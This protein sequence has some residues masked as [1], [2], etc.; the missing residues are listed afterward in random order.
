MMPPSSRPLAHNPTPDVQDAEPNH[1]TPISYVTESP[2]RN[3]QKTMEF[4]HSLAFELLARVLAI[5]AWPRKFCESSLAVAM[6]AWM[7][8]KPS[9]WFLNC[10]CA[11]SPL[12]VSPWRVSLRLLILLKLSSI[13][14]FVF[15]VDTTI[16]ELDNILPSHAETL[17]QCVR[18]FNSVP[19]SFVQ[20]RYVGHMVVTIV[21][22]TWLLEALYSIVVKR[23]WQ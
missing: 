1:L 15:C 21:D 9:A 18:A 12:T 5:S 3:P 23:S 6:V 10:S 19:T 8:C 20:A 11:L 14:W 17:M 16:D 2:H 22:F 4:N 13:G 7:L